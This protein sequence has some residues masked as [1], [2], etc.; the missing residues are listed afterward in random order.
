MASGSQP[1]VVIPLSASGATITADGALKMG[2]GAEAEATASGT[3]QSV[4]IAD[5]AGTAH[6][7][8]GC[9]AGTAA[10]PG[11][12]VLNSLAI[13]TG[14]LVTVMDLTLPVGDSF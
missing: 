3:A 2:I 6:M 1:L 12:C 10:V 5:G 8:L 11:S 4:V 7:V 13:N 14:V 9:V